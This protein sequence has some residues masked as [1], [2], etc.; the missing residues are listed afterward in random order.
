MWTD[1]YPKGPT[2]V[3]D[4]VL[5]SK[6]L[7][8]GPLGALHR[9]RHLGHYDGAAE[10]GWSPDAQAALLAFQERHADDGLEATG[11]LD[12]K[13]VALLSKLHGH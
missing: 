4:L 1:E 3:L 2:V 8:D 13:T 6:P 5:D 12:S 7:P 10:D 9:L 11:E